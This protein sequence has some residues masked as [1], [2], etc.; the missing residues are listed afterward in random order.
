MKT[1]FSIFI[2]KNRLESTEYPNFLMPARVNL[3]NFDYNKKH[4]V[5][6]VKQGV[7]DCLKLSSNTV[8]DYY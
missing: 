2:E 4:I 3:Y 6:F 1:Y 8:L 7:N 5:T